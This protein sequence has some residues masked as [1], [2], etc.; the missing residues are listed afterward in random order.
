MIV[1]TF[2]QSHNLGEVLS[3]DHKVI[4][5][6]DVHFKKSLPRT[7]LCSK[8]FNIDDIAKLQ[9]AVDDEYYFEWFLDELPIWG[10]VGD[11]PTAQDFILPQGPIEIV[12]QKK[13]IY[14]HMHFTIN[15]NGDR[16]VEWNATAISDYR[17][18]ITELEPQTVDFR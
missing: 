7:P 9:R 18:D 16:I 12:S 15:Y 6:Y 11:S 13:Y 14:T 1:E 10:Y 8:T 2:V 17:A 5:A 4:S 3:G